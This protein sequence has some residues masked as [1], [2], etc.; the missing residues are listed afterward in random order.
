MSAVLH[1]PNR[2]TRE[3]RAM[4]R[5]VP[6]K[7]LVRAQDGWDT[8][9]FP[10]LWVMTDAA[11]KQLVAFATAG[12]EGDVFHVKGQGVLPKWRGHGYQRRLLAAQLRYAKRLGFRVV[13]TYAKVNNARSIANLVRGGLIP[14]SVRDGFVYFEKDLAP[15]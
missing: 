14:V 10:L 13:R 15:T 9:P 1:P 8:S 6:K 12:I 5:R 7:L 3:L 2:I 4:A 11:S